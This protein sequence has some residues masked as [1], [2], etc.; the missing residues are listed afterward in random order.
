VSRANVEVVGR[1]LDAFNAGDAEAA[2]ASL[3]LDVEW[4]LPPNFPESGSLR[5]R[6]RVVAQLVGL[7]EGWDD[8]LVD[9]QELGR[10]RP[11]GGR[12]RPRVV[13]VRMYGGTDEALADAGVRR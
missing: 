4:H 13:E 3:D 9:V 11:P 12:A 7:V 10:R 8:L 5:G 1:A 2:A 6:E